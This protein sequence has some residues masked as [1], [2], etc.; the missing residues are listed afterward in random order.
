[1]IAVFSKFLNENIISSKPADPAIDPDK[2]PVRA[3]DP[4]KT[5]KIATIAI[6]DNR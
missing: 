1:M 3:T 4:H 2:F 6:A 5:Q